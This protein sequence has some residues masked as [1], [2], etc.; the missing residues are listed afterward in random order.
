[1]SDR[2]KWCGIKQC[3]LIPGCFYK[4]ASE[5][6]ALEQ[7]AKGSEGGSREGIWGGDLGVS[8]SSLQTT[9]AWPLWASAV[10]SVKCECWFP[11]RGALGA[12]RPLQKELAL[13]VPG[14]WEI[15][16]LP[17]SPL[18]DNSR[19]RVGEG[20]FFYLVKHH[21][22][23]Q[24]LNMG[25]YGISDTNG[26]PLHTTPF[27]ICGTLFNFLIPKLCGFL[28]F[29]SLFISMFLVDSLSLQMCL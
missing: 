6:V 9:C 10:S 14:R 11:Q 16:L 19:G 22:G 17:L 18:L 27:L 5:K 21:T 4:K 7:K 29:S 3:L 8:L 1:M 2:N 15:L 25:S 12:V 13:G 23:S 28:H 26:L 24:A 20:F